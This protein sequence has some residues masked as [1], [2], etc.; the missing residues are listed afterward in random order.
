MTV[1]VS[2][3]LMGFLRWWIPWEPSAIVVVV[4]AAAACLYWRG[5]RRSPMT[6]PWHRQWLFWLGLLVL[7]TGLHT[8]LDYY[9]EHEF[10]VHRIQHLGLHHLGPFLIALAYPGVTM[11]RGLPL[12]WRARYLGR[13]LAWTPVRKCLDVLLHPFNAALLFVG[14]IYLWLWPAVHFAAMLD[15]RL[16]HLMNYSM[17]AD[18]VLFWWLI[19]DRRSRPPARLSPGVRVFVALAVIPPQILIGAYLS[20]TT[21]NLYPIYSLCGRAFAGI[22]PLMDQHLG[23]LILWIPSSMMSVLA[24][25]IAFTHWLRLDSKGRLPR[26]RRQRE[27]MRARQAASTVQPEEGPVALAGS[28]EKPT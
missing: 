10:F 28:T 27:L 26:N 15:W 6:T 25:V 12:R 1:E 11:R 14:L 19:L 18:G 5:A 21:T 17:A 2:K 4:F 13:V 9:A 8:H 20:F 22:P 23:G 16:Y 3:V 7:Y 24:A